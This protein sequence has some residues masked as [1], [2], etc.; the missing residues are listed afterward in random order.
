MSI[1]ANVASEAF[2]V[3]PAERVYAGV[4]VFLTGL[5]VNVSMAA[6]EAWLPGHDLN[7]RF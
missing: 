5:A 7:S 6:I 1:A 3:G 2:T 4:P